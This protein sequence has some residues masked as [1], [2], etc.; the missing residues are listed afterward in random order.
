[1]AVE[2]VELHLR[3]GTVVEAHE[4]L[5][6][7]AEGGPVAPEDRA[8]VLVVTADDT[9]VQVPLGR[10]AHDRLRQ[11][12]VHDRVET[13]AGQPLR[14][15]GPDLAHDVRLGVHRAAAAPEL[16]PERLVADLGGHVEAP[17][18]DPEAQPVLGH[19]HDVGADLGV[20]GVE[21]G[22]GRQAPPGPVPQVPEGLVAALVFRDAD[23]RLVRGIQ[24]V[25]GP[26]VGP[27][28]T[29]ALEGGPGE[30]EPVAVRGAGAVLQDVV[31]RPEPA[32]RVVEH[33]VEHDAHPA[34]VRRVQQLAQGVVAA[35]ERVDLQVVERVVAV[36][37]GRLEDRGEVDRRDTEVRE[38]REPLR[39]AQEVS[40]LEPVV[41][42]RR[43]PGLQRARLP[44]PQGRGEPVREDLVEDRVANPLR[45]V[46]DHGYLMTAGRADE[47]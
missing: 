43:V 12:V 45:G 24:R 6:L 4:A 42:R 16:L 11:R 30:V 31:E 1:M 35:Q 25:R 5:E 37:G 29:V 36:V 23:E 26:R 21:L 27:E 41:G 2:E 3:H 46:D 38:V 20:V 39:D 33:P 17:A 9:F 40:A 28:R 22:Q 18:V 15:L 13:I 7:R 32:P 19:L 47:V 14:A 34:R 8:P 10:E 44:D